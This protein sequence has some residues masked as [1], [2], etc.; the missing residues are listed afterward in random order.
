METQK[1]EDKGNKKL[2]QK[3]RSKL[4]VILVLIIGFWIGGGFGVG[5]YLDKYRP[6]LLQQKNSAWVG[7]YAD[8]LEK[9]MEAEKNDFYGGDTPEET[10]DMFIEA[11]KNG[12]GY[13]A[14]KYFIL[15]EQEKW[16]KSFEQSTKENIDNWVT[17]LENAK[18]RWRKEQLSDI[19]FVFKYNTG[20][21]DEEI[22]NFIYL[23][24]NINNKWKIEGF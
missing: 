13:A 12:D 21:G 4:A 22:T 10:V 9:Q 17:E 23:R 11:L 2:W 20:V 19:K 6:Y 15:N 14:N 18:K 24:K 8:I 1:D 3:I 7:V 16:N 5:L